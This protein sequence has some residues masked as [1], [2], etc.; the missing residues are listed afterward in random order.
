MGWKWEGSFTF[1]RSPLHSELLERAVK[2]FDNADDGADDDDDDANGW[3][4]EEANDA[5]SAARGF[6]GPPGATGSREGWSGNG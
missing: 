2:R 3:F 5:V 1:T 6:C 4:E